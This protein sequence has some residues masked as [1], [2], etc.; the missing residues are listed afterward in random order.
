VP[1][2]EPEFPGEFPTLGY[3]VAS[4]IQSSCVIPDG[5]FAGEPYVLT[6]EM[7]RFLLWYYRIDPDS[8]RFYYDRGAQLVRP[9]KWGKGPFGAAMIC[10]EA[11]EDGPV[12]PAGWDAAGEPVGKPWP[13]P[14]IQA[15]AVSE[16]QTDNVWRMLIPMI[17]RGALSAAIWDTGETR[18]NLPSGGR[19]EPPTA[20]AR[21]RLGQQLTFC[22][23][24]QTESWTERNG[25]RLLAD[26]QRRNLAGMG[27]RFVETC[28]A[29]DPR[30]NSVAQRTAESGE[31]GVYFDDVDPG[32][33]S[34]H[35]KADRRRML[36][37]VYGHSNWVDLDRIDS[38]VIALLKRGEVAQAE[39]YFFN[40]KEAGEDAAF[41]P[42]QI[43][44]RADKEYEPAAGALIAIG[45]DGAR[46][47]DA[48]AVV[49]TEIET[50]F[51][52]P[53]GIWERPAHAPEDY[54]H[55]PDE[56]DGVMV[57]AFERFQV[58]RVYID[59]QWI[60]HLLERWQGR[61]G[62]KRV[63]PW[64]TNR[65]RQIAWAVRSYVNAFAAGDNSHSGE[66]TFV[67][68]LKQARKQKVNVFDDKHRQM[69]T[70]SKDSPDSPRKMD[71]AMAGVLSWEARGDAIAAN[72]KPRSRKP[73]RL[74]GFS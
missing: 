26:T 56:V 29:W 38:E 20:S 31:P 55:P 5:E 53:L 47:V 39:R 24:D 19:I 65:P 68:H 10:A 60:D 35:N 32:P 13:T 67:R 64:Y 18:I 25:G 40:R 45:V 30:E 23:Q 3:Q 34:V 51:Q 22:L 12:R 46:F 28:N 58:W 62:Q 1:W 36:R 37:K 69:H 50:G 57:E 6:D 8:G 16:G 4:W 44:A 66:E 61:W 2:R 71:G 43:N 74:V 14:F 41:R 49:A 42:D 7:L 17:E 72:A 48:L 33:G 54:E 27:G 59:P 52:W 70:L 9:Q 11:A 21:S 73:A 15:T 63:I